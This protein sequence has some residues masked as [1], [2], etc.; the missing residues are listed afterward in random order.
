MP[1]KSEKK[2]KNEKKIL[3]IANKINKDIINDKKEEKSVN[4]KLSEEEKVKK[5]SKC[6]KTIIKVYINKIVS[7]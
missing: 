4:Y 3:K 6:V 7:W 1:V 2:D 5:I